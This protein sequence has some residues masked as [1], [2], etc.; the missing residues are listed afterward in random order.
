MKIHEFT[1]SD[2][3]LNERIKKIAYEQL[4]SRAHWMFVHEPQF[5][6]NFIDWVTDRL[7]HSSNVNKSFSNEDISNAIFVEGN[8][9]DSNLAVPMDPI[10]KDS[11]YDGFRIF[12][13][14]NFKEGENYPWLFQS[15]SNPKFP[16]DWIL[17]NDQYPIVMYSSTD[18]IIEP[19]LDINRSNF[20]E[21]C[22]AIKS[23]AKRRNGQYIL[24]ASEN[25]K[26]NSRI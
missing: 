13:S 6:S 5:Q 7:Q 18:K 20:E 1:A 23:A 11:I 17:W 26:N 2:A 3:T 24:S 15:S 8:I 12:Q 10:D 22:N 9:L 4:D 25:I 19:C 21:I 14:N 16:F